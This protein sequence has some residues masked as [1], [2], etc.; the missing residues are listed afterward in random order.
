MRGRPP[1]LVRLVVG[2]LA[3]VALLV[4]VLQIRSQAHHA[5]GVIPTLRDADPALLALAILAELLAYL[6]PGV[7]LRV[8]VPRLPYAATMRIAVAALGAGALLPGQPLPGGG[9]AYRE[10][11]RRDVPAKRAAAASTALMLVIPAASMAL[12]AGPGL[13]VSG[14]RSPLPA[15]WRGVVDAAAVASFLLALAIVL[16]V[17]VRRTGDRVPT[18][19]ALG[20]L[21]WVADAACLWLTGEALHI[22]LDPASLPVAY[23]TAAVIIALPVLPGGLGA[24]EATV[25]L[26][27]AAGGDPSY[28]NAALVVICWRVLSF[29]IPTVAGV[30]ALASLNPPQVKVM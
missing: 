5:R 16:L 11:R 21:A 30:G 9:I 1:W 17:A 19:L 4:A 6:A 20:A 15:G 3:G 14:L 13:L 8:L 22:H 12:L 26:I 25:P 10:L 2:T 29:W 23:V 24:V 28:A 27:L 18:V 7:M